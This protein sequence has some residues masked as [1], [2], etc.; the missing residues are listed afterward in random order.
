[1]KFLLCITLLLAFGCVTTTGEYER[2]PTGL[3]RGE[4][5]NVIKKNLDQIRVCYEQLLQRQ[6]DISGK[7]SVAFTIDASG[8]VSSLHIKESTIAEQAFNDCVTSRIRMWQFPRPRD[9]KNISIIYP[10]IFKPI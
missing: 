10:F 5:D 2:Q 6:P 8:H 3:A 9:G 7:I 1:M 4:I